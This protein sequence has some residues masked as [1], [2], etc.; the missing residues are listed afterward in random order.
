METDKNAPV[1]REELERLEKQLSEKR[2]LND[3]LALKAQIDTL[4]RAVYALIAT[5]PCRENAKAVFEQYAEAL[6]ETHGALCFEFFLSPTN[7]QW[8]MSGLRA[9]LSEWA[10]HFSPEC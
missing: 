2:G 9:H 3:L 10:E 7:A 1:T 8:H 4:Q 5:H 6:K